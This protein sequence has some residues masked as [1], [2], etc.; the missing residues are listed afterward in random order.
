MEKIRK[1][2]KISSALAAF[3]WVFTPI[4]ALAVHF[5]VGQAVAAQGGKVTDKAAPSLPSCGGNFKLFTRPPVANDNGNLVGLSPLGSQSAHI[6]PPDH[7]YFWYKTT[8]NPGQQLVAPSDGWVV[9]VTAN[10]F[11]T[12]TPSNYFIGFSPCAEVTLNFLEIP[13]ISPALAAGLAASTSVT[14]C[15][16]FN[17]GGSEV[18]NG[19]VT[20]MQ[21]PV[22]AGDI[23]GSGVINDFGPLED[24]RVNLTGFANPSRHDLNRGFCP[25]DYFQTGVLLPQYT[26][27]G[28]SL[29]A[30]NY[31]SILR[32]TTPACGTIVQ[33]IPGTAQGD[34]YTQATA[35]LDENAQMSLVHDSI[36]WSSA[37]F[38]VGP[39]NTLSPSLP[40][41]VEKAYFLP[42][43][44]PDGSFKVDSSSTDIDF[45]LVGN[46]GYTYCYDSLSTSNPAY[47]P[48]YASLSGY[49]VLVKLADPSDL[50]IEVQ[51]KAN[52][53][54]AAPWA[55]TGAAVPFQR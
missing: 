10:T 53:A 41:G 13:S 40:S 12:S 45:S 23:L 49:I 15:S 5:G 18:G 55:L 22:R 44:N 3:L 29:G 51:H 33:D 26:S 38:S 14:T 42:K 9:Q 50:L 25:L 39:Q 31:T 17:N 32:S 21:L 47:A 28:F 7:M 54:A 27:P 6:L 37:V 52:C 2:L 43:T 11:Y 1:G 19:C 4:P 24:T 16:S 36:F 8:S 46:D 35:N 30:P 20:N 34:W 48:S